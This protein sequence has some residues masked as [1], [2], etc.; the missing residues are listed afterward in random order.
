[1]DPFRHRPVLQVTD[2]F[3][4]EISNDVGCR[5]REVTNAAINT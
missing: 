3:S 1:M 2:A 4:R 5:L